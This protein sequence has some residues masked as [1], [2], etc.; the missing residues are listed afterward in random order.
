MLRLMDVGK[1]A[2]TDDHCTRKADESEGFYSTA[3]RRESG[4][5]MGG[6]RGARKREGL[7]ETRAYC[8][9][10]NFGIST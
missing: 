3:I 1:S 8:Q 7:C 6:W 4:V 9:R 2:M 10:A 5:G